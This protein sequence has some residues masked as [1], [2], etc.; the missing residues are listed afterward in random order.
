MVHLG[1]LVVANKA[2]RIPYRIR[3]HSERS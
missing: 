3:Y 2:R 1:F